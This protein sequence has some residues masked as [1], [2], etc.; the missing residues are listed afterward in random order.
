M[1]TAE[2]ASGRPTSPH[3]HLLTSALGAVLQILSVLCYDGN[4]VLVSSNTHATFIRAN[5]VQSRCRRSYLDGLCTEE[6]NLASRRRQW[7]NWPWKVQTFKFA[8]IHTALDFDPHCARHTSTAFGQII[9]SNFSIGHLHRSRGLRVTYP[10]TYVSST[11]DPRWSFCL[12]TEQSVS[13][14]RPGTLIG[15]NHITTRGMVS[16]GPHESW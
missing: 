5:S 7:A 8:L 3:R 2:Q 13:R 1:L 9:R 11:S 4:L 10:G 15:P 14:V 16:R 12:G 6:E